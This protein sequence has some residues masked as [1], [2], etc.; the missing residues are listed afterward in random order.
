M[1]N[2]IMK[3]RKFLDTTSDD[4]IMIEDAYR[5]YI[6]K[7]PE[8]SFLIWPSLCRTYVMISIS[9][10]EYFIEYVLDNSNLK[11]EGWKIN[12]EKIIKKALN[13][14]DLP[15]ELDIPG[16]INRFICLRELR[17]YITH[18]GL[19]N[20]TKVRVNRIGLNLDIEKY[21]EQEFT[22]IKRIVTDTINLI[23]MSYALIEN[24]NLSE[25]Q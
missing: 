21:N 10:I 11:K 12:L 7:H 6:E 1:L 17:H 25:I 19:N 8:I 3:E 13:R 22:I 16:K 9:A 5:L 24:P 18:T 4:L 20:K 15:H 2:D 23:G 14:N